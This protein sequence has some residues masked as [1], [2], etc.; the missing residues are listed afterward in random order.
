VNA[1]A[2]VDPRLVDQFPADHDGYPP[3]AEGE[4]RVRGALSDAAGEA[5]REFPSNLWIEPRDW[6]E[7]ARIN[8]EDHTWPIHYVDRFTNQNPTHE[9]TCHALRAVME[10]ARNRQRRIALGPPVAGQRLPASARSASVWL[11]PLSVYAEA[12]PRQ[13]GG[14]STRGVMEIAARRGMLPETIQPRD[15]GFAHAIHGTCGKGGVNQASGSWLPLGKF[16]PGW[17]QTARHFRPLEV[18]IPESVE[19]IVALVCNSLAVGVGRKG[20]AI[21]YAIFNPVQRLLGYVDSYD[22]IRWDSLSTAALTLGSAYAIA[23]TT[24][25]D[26]WDRPAQ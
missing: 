9:C 21:P 25:P 8:D 20:H 7:A 10:S 17:E 23:T 14:A 18:I 1:F 11:S 12:N 2:P 6:E 16:P 5:A 13:W 22:V 4:D 15:W 24:V 26:D 19:Q 3:E